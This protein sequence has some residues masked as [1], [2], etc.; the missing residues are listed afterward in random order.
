MTFPSPIMRSGIYALDSLFYVPERSNVPPAEA[1]TS[2][3]IGPDGSGKSLLAMHYASTYVYDC[4]KA[5]GTMPLVFYASTDLSLVQAQS[6][7]SSFGLGFPGLRERTIDQVYRG[8]TPWDEATALRDL[9]IEENVKFIHVSPV[10]GEPPG[11]IKSLSLSDVVQSPDDYRGTF[12]FLDLQRESAGDDWTF[13]NH[14]LGLLTWQTKEKHPPLLVIDA[15]EGLETYVGTR[16]SH[17]QRRPRRSRVA[18]L[19]RTCAQSN[20][21][22]VL[23]IEESQE[24]RR[25]PEQFVSD[26]V[27]RLRK[28]S[29]GN[30]TTRTLEIEKCRGCG[31]M[32][33][34][35]D[36]YIRRGAGTT[37][38]EQRHWDHRVIAWGKRKNEPKYL[39]H[40]HLI[41]S[42]EYIDAL[43]RGNDIPVPRA[44]GWP[45]FGL[46]ALNDQFP[47]TTENGNVRNFIHMGSL[48]LLLGDAGTMKSRLALNFLAHSFGE[49]DG[50][51]AIL[52]TN[53]LYDSAQLQK[54]LVFLNPSANGKPKERFLCR[55]LSTRYIS[56][57]QFIQIVMSYVHAAQKE[58]LVKAG[59]HPFG[60]TEVMSLN[61]SDYIRSRAADSY[62]I[63]V[64][65]DDWNLILTSHPNIQQDPLFL[66]TLLAVLQREGVT[67]LIVSTESVRANSQAV[68]G[69]PNEL[70]KLDVPHVYTWSVPFFGERRIAITTNIPKGAERYPEVHELRED[71]G[72]LAVDR[73]FALYTGLDTSAPR[74]VPLLIRL[75]GGM[76]AGHQDP[77]RGMQPSFPRALS[78]ML[79]QL[80]PAMPENDVVKFEPFST[81]DDFFAFASWLDEARLDHTVVFQIDEFWRSNN[82]SLAPLTDYW[83]KD[84][85]ASKSEDN[86]EV[87]D[88]NVNED[89][90]DVFQPHVGTNGRTIFAPEITHKYRKKSELRRCDTFFNQSFGAPVKDS[91]VDRIPFLW[92]FGMILARKDLWERCVS[93]QT[94]NSDVDVSEVWNRLCRPGDE[95]GM[96][97]YKKLDEVS[98][99]AFFDAC[100]RVASCAPDANV[101]PFDVDM[102]TAESLSCLFLEVWASYVA[103]ETFAPIADRTSREDRTIRGLLENEKNVM[104]L[105]CACEQI[106]SVT[107]HLRAKQS[108]VVRSTCNTEFVAS[109]EWYS[110]SSAIMSR[111]GDHHQYSLLSVPGCY[112]TRGDWFLAVA[113]G[114]RSQLVGQRA[115]D[116]LSSRRLALLRMQDGLGLAVRDILPDGQIDNLKS[117]ITRVNPVT[118]QVEYLNYGDICQAGPS[119]DRLNLKWLWR[120]RLKHYARDSF[121]L[122]RWIARL[123]E[124]QRNWL[125]NNYMEVSHQK[126]R[127]YPKLL[128]SKM[129]ES[130]PEFMKRVQILHSALWE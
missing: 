109:R 110:T 14:L 17:G 130:F 60:P 75:Y 121:F 128:R 120:S 66:P 33:G 23:V 24:G 81:Y 39:A 92:D 126:K 18:Q 21:H 36:Y 86:P 15:V 62:R 106:L 104:A 8:F 95:I 37:T 56:S 20:A 88:R 22:L 57:S 63:R 64:V 35:N 26:V 74:R 11:N 2:C 7:W 118:K 54:D 28:E 68:A 125:P 105:F 115:I 111:A 87:F 114:S 83:N 76:H 103:E 52:L 93:Q 58:L 34:T 30:E 129:G 89:V 84:I 99:L 41:P 123:Y 45:T 91:L 78:Q 67:A 6:A 3:I 122:R 107:G 50:G 80:F 69:T 42:L 38:G 44:I 72:R 46:A 32:S 61:D 102:N 85:V 12:L 55:R 94:K 13:L 40:F 65:I 108:N 119:P 73:H 51:A 127:L 53:G 10:E 100:R 29:H 77:P 113:K 96:I 9:P 79:G 59:K 101:V 90:Y 71:A 98:W 82:F 1:V 16:D 112:S 97:P 4:R 31:H 43:F 5:G 117:A 124:E 25:L 49:D 48:T 70:R 116:L 19:T 27:L 47:K